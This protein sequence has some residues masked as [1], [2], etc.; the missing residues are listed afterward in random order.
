MWLVQPVRIMAWPE[1]PDPG[2]AVKIVP[3]WGLYLWKQSLVE[4]FLL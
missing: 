3:T 2:E 4:L 1:S